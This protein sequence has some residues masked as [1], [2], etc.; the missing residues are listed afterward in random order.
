MI[1][2][3]EYGI[4]VTDR[5]FCAGKIIKYTDKKTG[6][7]S[8]RV[9]GGYYTSLPDACKGL[10]KRYTLD[11]LKSFEGDL[12]SA[13]E[14]LNKRTSAFEKALAAVLPEFKMPEV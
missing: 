6:N 1:R 12:K 8:E 5:C 3:G 14:Y 10:Y 9:D 11:A 13:I 7:P 4:E 2:I